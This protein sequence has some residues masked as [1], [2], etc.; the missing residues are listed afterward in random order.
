VLAAA[1]AFVPSAFA[2]S[3]TPPDG[4]HGFLLR[5]DE[6]AQ[7]THTFSRT[8]SF[9]WNPVSGATRYEFQLSTSKSFADNALVW[10]DTK[11]DGPLTT[12]P[13]TLPWI[14]GAKYSWFAR[15]RAVVAGDEGPWSFVYGFNMRAGGAPRSLSNG[16]NP[17]PG[18]VRWTPV[19][20]ATAYEVVFLYDL[21]QAKSK[22]IRTATTAADL[23]EYYSF[24]NTFPSSVYWRV[25]AIRQ[26]EGKPLNSIPVVSYGPWSARNR[27][28]EPPLGTSPV[29]LQGAIS[30]SRAADVQGTTAY[31]GA[32]ELDPG[33]WWSGSRTL[34]PDLFGACPA[35]VE[36]ALGPSAAG[37]CPLFHVYVYSDPD[38]VN[39]VHVSDL[40]GSPAY[41]PR[42]TGPLALP[43]DASSLLK[44]TN[45]YLAD[46][47]KEG[48]V[49]DAGGEPVLPTGV[50]ADD[51]APMTTTDSGS[52]GSDAGSSDS[53]A[54][55]PAAAVTDRKN[56][57]WDND[58][59]T[60]RYYWVVVPAVP[61][62]TTDGKIEYHD[63]AF[64]EDACAA[65][66]VMTFGK[67]SA[68]AT[69]AESG[70]PYASGLSSDGRMVAAASTSPTFFG[71]PLIAW[72]PAPGAQRYEVQ[73]SRTA[74]PWRTAGK[75]VT[76]AT[77]ALLDLPTGTWYYRV[78]GLD[79]T[80]P[81][82]SGLTWSDVAQL[83]IQPRTFQVVSKTTALTRTKGRHR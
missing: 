6:A 57:F 15:V 23:R 52:S 11:V 83:Q 48:S 82:P 45:L 79:E 14:G 28:I 58:W 59:P 60:S 38:C 68:A 64:G 8:P 40:V 5:A 22:K 37:A 30:R 70:I 77:G 46:A 71:K 80:L 56:S 4:L 66:Q 65:G 1:L 21:G 20:G 81:G 29:Q 50:V 41:V 43:G 25:R 75:L 72:Q 32:H 18:M 62:V 76:P 63:V 67:T 42:L 3:S 55:A 17:N 9:A 61:H 33:F 36:L 49:F 47:P 13:L 39:R 73:W 53:S 26:V 7:P 35:E 51:S 16:N 10:E 19:Q 54:T 2:G 44:A 27:T 69:T 74:Y 12:V 31:P 24:H 78:R 34:A